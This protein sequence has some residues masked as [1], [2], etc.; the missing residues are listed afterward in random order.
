MPICDAVNLDGDYCERYVE[1][2]VTTSYYPPFQY[3]F[4][5]SSALLSNYA[6]VFAF[7]FFTVTFIT[8][9]RYLFLCELG[10][11]VAKSRL[12][13]ETLLFDLVNTIVPPIAK[14]FEWF[15]HRTLANKISLTMQY[16]LLSAAKYLSN[17]RNP[18]HK[19]DNPND[20]VGDACVDAYIKG[21][22][23]SWTNY[24]LSLPP[25]SS[26]SPTTVASASSSSSQSQAQSSERKEILAMNIRHIRLFSTDTF[27]AELS[28]S[29]STILTFGVVFPPLAALGLLAV[30]SQSY[31]A[32]F[33][34]QRLWTRA[35]AQRAVVF[36]KMID[37]DC[38]G[39]AGVLNR[40]MLRLFVVDA[41]AVD[42][43]DDD[44]DVGDDD[45]Y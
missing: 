19:S 26:P 18:L 8:P 5:C 30:A 12:S 21:R 11:S 32:Q 13:K 38:K 40:S 25:S 10:K 23:Q 37:R 45:Q 31:L 1:T 7:V 44:D 41:V 20:E 17:T 24:F 29:I 9:L 4:E 35:E 28:L 34:V 33:L 42:D 36:M 27:V 43:D 6:S 22:K 3:S 15:S 2:Q 14:P 39:V 16:Y